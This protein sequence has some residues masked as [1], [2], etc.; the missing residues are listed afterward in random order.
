MPRRL[1]LQLVHLL[2]IIHVWAQ[3]PAIPTGANPRVPAPLFQLSILMTMMPFSD[4]FG[5]LEQRIIEVSDFHQV[6]SFSSIHTF[7]Y[8][9]AS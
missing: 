4:T 1:H 6:N 7:S 5:R 2:P 9:L 8:T 3:V